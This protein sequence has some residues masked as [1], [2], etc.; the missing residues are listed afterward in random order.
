MTIQIERAH[1]VGLRHGHVVPHADLRGGHEVPLLQFLGVG[2]GHAAP[3]DGAGALGGP[4]DLEGPLG[5]EPVAD[6]AHVPLRPGPLEQ[7]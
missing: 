3:H 1:V 5:V 6:H 2:V 7:E 4:A